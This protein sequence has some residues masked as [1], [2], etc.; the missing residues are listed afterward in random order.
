MRPMLAIRGGTVPGISLFSL[1][2]RAMIQ[3]S[4]SVCRSSTRPPKD[5]TQWSR[6]LP[7]IPLTSGGP[8]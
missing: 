7:F 1:L 8:C 3:P 4:P 2:T 5:M 6:V